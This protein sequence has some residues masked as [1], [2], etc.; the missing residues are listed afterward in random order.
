[1]D[2]P[3]GPEIAHWF[4]SNHSARLHNFQPAEGLPALVREGGSYCYVW[5]M[6]Y[7]DLDMLA[8]SLLD[9]RT[10]VDEVE[11][12]DFL[13]CW[14]G[15]DGPGCEWHQHPLATDASTTAHR[16]RLTRGLTWMAETIERHMEET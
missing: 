13:L 8:F 2:V 12:R 3:S 9:V 4:R 10:R 11:T 15:W 16:E 14:E 6:A 5:L 1:M 7:V